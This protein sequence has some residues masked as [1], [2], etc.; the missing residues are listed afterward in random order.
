MVMTVTVA[1]ILIDKDK[2]YE[3][4]LDDTVGLLSRGVF[5]DEVPPAKDAK[6][7]EM[8]HDAQAGLD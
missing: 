2:L 1:D 8:W 7:I 3:K 6:L 4:G 5:F